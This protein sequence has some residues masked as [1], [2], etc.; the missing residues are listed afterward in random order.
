[1]GDRVRNG[2][3]WGWS[4]GRELAERLLSLNSSTSRAENWG[5]ASADGPPGANLAVD[6]PAV[7]NGVAPPLSSVASRCGGAW[8]GILADS[9]VGSRRGE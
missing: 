7:P 3:G 1:M 8:V 5:R 9:G 6:G 2:C 4:E